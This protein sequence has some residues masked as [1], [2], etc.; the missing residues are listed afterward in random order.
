MKKI[1][2][3]ICLFVFVNAS[4]KKEFAFKSFDEAIQGFHNNII[5]YGSNLYF[6]NNENDEYSV[7][8]DPKSTIEK[9]YS[10]LQIFNSDNFEDVLVEY[11]KTAD[12][13]NLYIKKFHKFY[14]LR[15]L[16]KDIKYTQKMFLQLEERFPNIYHSKGS[17]K[18][19]KKKTKDLS[20]SKVVFLKDRVKKIKTDPLNEITISS[21][22]NTTIP[23]LT[24]QYK[25]KANNIYRPN[26]M[27]IV[28]D[29][30]SSESN[31]AIVRGD[32]LGFKN[33]GTHNLSVYN[34]YGILCQTS[35]NI[36][37]LVS[38]QEINSLYDLRDKILSVGEVSDIA[39]V[40]IQS[41]IKD[42]G[43]IRDIH[44]QSLS[45]NDSIKAL[46]KKKIDAFFLFAPKETIYTYLKKGFHIS[47]IPSDMRKH[48]NN[49]EGLSSFK[50]KIDERIVRTYKVPNFV[51]SPIATLDTDITRKIEVVGDKFG[52]FDTIKVPK[53]FFGQLHPEF[54]KIAEALRL[55]KLAEQ[56]KQKA[57]EELTI[58][59]FQ[60]TKYPEYTD[61][62]YKVSNNTEA[63]LLVSFEYFKTKLFDD[64]AIKPHHMIKL[65]LPNSV[66]KL[67]ANSTK[68]LSFQYKNPFTLRVDK[69]ITIDLIFKDLRYT[70]RFLTI[71]LE[72]GAIK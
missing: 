35:N 39:Q 67:D 71:P 53:A 5:T 23:N 43:I 28:K 60:K 38:N 8:Y 4:D 7:V 17:I 22:K 52:C 6:L 9:K 21:K 30:E 1:L 10:F 59:F 58:K 16:N 40:Y 48:L 54:L 65:A 57:M 63:E 62:V 14:F 3:I 49:E 18:K 33:A 12:K 26:N 41:M 56:N 29:L 32:V 13:K 50:Y 19:T 11:R 27:K 37:F 44:F 31:F 68:L 34:N 36:L 46:E 47:S 15:L 72:I 24:N 20:D 66:I 42:N 61:Y 70:D 25:I 45:V 51:V 2:L 55:K 64:Y 69:D